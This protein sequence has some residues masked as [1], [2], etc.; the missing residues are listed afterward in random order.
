MVCRLFLV[1]PLFTAACIAL[2]L[3]SLATAAARAHTPSSPSGSSH[4]QRLMLALFG[5]PLFSWAVAGAASPDAD[6]TTGSYSY[7]SSKAKA[8]LQRQKMEREQQQQQQQ[9]EQ[10]QQQ[11]HFFQQQQRRQQQQQHQ[12]RHYQQHHHHAEEHHHHSQQQGGFHGGGGGGFEHLFEALFGGANGGFQFSFNGGGMPFGAGGFGGGGHRPPQSSAE[13][14]SSP[15]FIQK[16]LNAFKLPQDATP[17][18]LKKV[19]RKL[20][21]KYHPDKCKEEKCETKM[22][23]VNRY[24]EALEKWMKNR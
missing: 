19:Y 16:A 17:A 1:L 22:I 8:R 5:Q 11:Q 3:Y 21:I 9:H 13:E 18:D 4:P 10:Q 23:K 7:V 14:D 15:R 24:K 2:R 12:Q 6:D 20:A